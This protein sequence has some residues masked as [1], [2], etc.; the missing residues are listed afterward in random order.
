M[1][2][3]WNTSI[4]FANAVMMIGSN[5]TPKAFVRV[6]KCVG[7]LDAMLDELDND[8]NLREISGKHTC[9][10]SDKDRNNYNNAT[11]AECTSILI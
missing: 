9:A 7:V 10:N 1:I 8:L 11:I 4:E 3:L 2:Y 5:K 6:G